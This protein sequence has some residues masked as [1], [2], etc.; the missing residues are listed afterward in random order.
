MLHRI[1]NDLMLRCALHCPLELAC[2]AVS[3]MDVF[4]HLASLFSL[5]VHQLAL[6]QED[7]RTAMHVEPGRPAPASSSDAPAG[8]GAPRPA[9][10]PTA[11]HQEE[12]NEDYAPRRHGRDY[13]NDWD[14]GVPST[15]PR[16][17]APSPA[18]PRRGGF[19]PARQSYDEYDRH[20]AETE[21]I[22]ANA[23]FDEPDRYC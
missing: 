19:P 4:L 9:Q 12:D 3:Y 5:T 14:R 1:A 13:D 23:E 17:P 20:R 7:I 11:P 18:P 10:P 16:G 22:W 6:L 15:A 8:S 2:P 21:R